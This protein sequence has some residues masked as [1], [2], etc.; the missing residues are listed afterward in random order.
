[1]SKRTRKKT[2]NNL[3]PYMPTLAQIAAACSEIRAEN[4][5]NFAH[6]DVNEYYDSS[7]GIRVIPC[8]VPDS[9][10]MFSE[11]DE[12]CDSDYWNQEQETF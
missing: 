9:R 4:D 7:P 6:R 1:M 8:H 5:R 3:P 11:R 10:A 12:L 2:N